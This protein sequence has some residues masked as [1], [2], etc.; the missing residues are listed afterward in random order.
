MLY[1]CVKCCETVQIV[2]QWKCRLCNH[3]PCLFLL[4]LLFRLSQ[5]FNRA[6]TPSTGKLSKMVEAIDFY[7]LRIFGLHVKLMTHRAN[8]LL[9]LIKNL[10]SEEEKNCWCNKPKDDFFSI[11]LQTIGKWL[12][13]STMSWFIAFVFLK[14]VHKKKKRYLL[15]QSIFRRVFLFA[16]M[17]PKILKISI[18]SIR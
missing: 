2:L 11:F 13:A 1:N 16:V 7:E 14:G 5:K 17:K 12:L 15:L 6:L 18:Q 3:C 10:F 8:W 4:F 9:T